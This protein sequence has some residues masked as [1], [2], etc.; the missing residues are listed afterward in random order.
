MIMFPA[1]HSNNKK[2]DLD[3][4]LTNKFN[5]LAKYALS[6]NDSDKFIDN[7]QNMESLNH[8]QI[9]FLYDCSINYSM[10]PNDN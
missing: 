7:L 6:P 3:S 9:H 2:A 4:I 10:K 1:G 8:K 5:N